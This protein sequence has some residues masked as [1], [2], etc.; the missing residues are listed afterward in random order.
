MIH[1]IKN[2]DISVSILHTG[3]E[4]CSIKSQTTQQEYMWDA[5]PQIWGSFA[6]VLFP[7]IGS[8]KDNSYV[9]KHKRYSV[10]KHGFI[11]NNKDLKVESKSDD[12]LILKYRYNEDSLKM[13]PFKFVFYITF[14]LSGNKL[15]VNHRVENLGENEMLFSL[16]AHPAFKC[17][18]HS[19]DIYEDYYIEFDGIETSDT[20]E[21]DSNGLTTGNTKAMLNNTHTLP[22]T[23]TLFNEDALIFKNLKS[24]KATLKCKH[25]NKQISVSFPD[26]NYLG[27]WAK[28]NAPFVCIEPWLGITDNQNSIGNFEDKEGLIK[29]KPNSVF[30]AKY[31]IEII[32]G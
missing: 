6:P 32:E 16:G 11:R 4:I 21:I 19:N 31:E 22:L 23:K 12:C 27:I 5:T 8:L 24:N 1:T 29:L 26:F 3:A 13:Y 18:I 10:P 9:Y 25:H 17:P 2:N 14:Q 20:W 7:I 30:E 28:P 15:I